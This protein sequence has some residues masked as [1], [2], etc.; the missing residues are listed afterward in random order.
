VHKSWQV[1]YQCRA[2]IQTTE[3][4]LTLE[5]FNKPNIFVST[6]YFFLWLFHVYYQ[7]QGEYFHIFLQKSPGSHLS[8]L[9]DPVVTFLHENSSP[10]GGCQPSALSVRAPVLSGEPCQDSIPSQQ[11]CPR[12]SGAAC[13]ESFSLLKRAKLFPEAESLREFARVAA[14]QKLSRQVLRTEGD[15][16][17][18]NLDAPGHWLQRAAQNPT[19]ASLPEPTLGLQQIPELPHP[20][21]YFCLFPRNWI[22]DI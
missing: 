4:L 7:R 10:V 16:H 18:G 1:L 3:V 17:M 8:L 12:Q 21:V 14:V 20:A 13:S 2:C 9:K 15:A 5:F 22:S 19:P 11:W 6:K